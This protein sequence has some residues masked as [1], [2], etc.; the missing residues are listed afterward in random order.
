MDHAAF[1]SRAKS[2]LRL[3]TE[4]H[5]EDAVAELRALLQDLAPATKAGI[6]EWHQQQAL[7]LLVEVLDSA[8]RDED[9][10]QAWEEL[11]EFTQHNSTYWQNALSSAKLSFARWANEH[12]PA[13]GS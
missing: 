5:P 1:A 7:S 8:G 6:S 10:R 12:P 3:Q 11:I 13:S 2:A 4:G 9:C